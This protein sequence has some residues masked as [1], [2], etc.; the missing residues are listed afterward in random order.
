[1]AGSLNGQVA[2]VTGGGRGIGRAI[3]QAFAAEGAAVAA[4]SRSEAEVAETVR[5]VEAAGGTAL[6][7]PADVTDPAAVEHTVR[8]VEERLGPITV[9]VNNA[10]TAESGGPIWETDPEVW[11]RTVAINLRGTFLCSH[12]VMRGMVKR[13]RGRVINLDG[14][15]SAYPQP[16]FT[17]YAG[18]KAAILRLTDTVAEEAR[19]HGVS[20]FAIMPGLVQTRMGEIAKREVARARDVPWT[21]PERPAQLCVF[22]ASG[23]ADTLSGRC[24]SVRDNVADLVARAQEIQEQ[25]L[26]QLRI[27]A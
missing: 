5:L 3:C 15:G 14:G 17:A 27:R 8:A 25:D 6:G 24:L 9:L 21:P 10:G 1:M 2:L 12:F 18:S 13:G 23:K 26:H 4:L 22:L 7:V 11:W 19:M 16:R 20:V